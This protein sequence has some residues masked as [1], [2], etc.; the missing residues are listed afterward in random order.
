MSDLPR[1]TLCPSLSL[2][3][4]INQRGKLANYFPS[5]LSPDRLA[6]AVRCRQLAATLINVG[7]D[8]RTAD[9]TLSQIFI[10]V[11]LDFKTHLL[12]TCSL[13]S[14]IFMIVVLQ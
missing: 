4:T 1:S 8:T 10:N 7:P 2:S 3:F 6:G 5:Y 12:N 13:L 14:L 11:I 9:L